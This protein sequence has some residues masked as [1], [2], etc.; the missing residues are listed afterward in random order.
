MRHRAARMGL[1]GSRHE[2]CCQIYVFTVALAHPLR[3]VLF[4]LFVDRHPDKLEFA[5]LVMEDKYAP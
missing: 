5:D 4:W 1:L 2:C 3:E